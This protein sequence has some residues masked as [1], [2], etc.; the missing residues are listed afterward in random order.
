LL[1]SAFFPNQLTVPEPKWHELEKSRPLLFWIYSHCSTPYLVKTPL[2]QFI[3]LLLFLSTLVCTCDRLKN[4]LRRIPEFSKEKAFSFVTQ[5]TAPSDA[6]SVR[7]EIEGILSAGGWSTSAEVSDPNAVVSG[8]KGVSGFWGSVVFHAGLLFLFLAAPVTALTGFSG[9]LIAT[10]G[11]VQSLRG[12]MIGGV[13]R[14]ADLPDL[15]VQV[16]KL[17]GE[18]Y[19]GQYRYDFGGVLTLI[20]GA[21]RT[22]IPFAVNRP[23]DYAGYQF[24]LHEYG[25]APRLVLEREGR[26]WFDGFLNLRHPDEGDYF[27]LGDGVQ[28]M[29]IFFPDFIRQGSKIGTK[30]LRH[31]NPVTMV[32]LLRGG[33]EIYKGL[34][35]PGET[36]SWEGGRIAVPEC[37]RWAG[38][39]VA[40]ER[41]LVL[42]AIGSILA[43]A[44]L[45]ARF[46]SNERRI[47]FE[48]A[49]CE[50]GTAFQ[51]KGYS[52]YYP[53]F[54]EK[55][56]LAL[57]QTVKELPPQAAAGDKR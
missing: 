43:L 6:A 34:L 55:E 44:G 7:R 42:V 46:L 3:S 29:V 26:T 16:A 17:R 25:N 4:R 37:S 51:V 47:E 52:R 28:A 23:A 8:D 54:L 49:P 2:F 36:G 30:S 1:V 9:E 48:I 27:D 33:K 50:A 40:K 35:R 45:L 14:V 38:L 10:D 31:D 12:G 32:R 13:G 18:Y 19:E 53:A 11:E 56:V 5:E 15:Q 20:N 24:S 41:G 21:A 39:I 22:E 57:A